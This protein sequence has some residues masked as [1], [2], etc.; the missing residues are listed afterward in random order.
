MQRRGLHG[1]NEILKSELMG[2][3]KGRDEGDL[4]VVDVD[5]LSKILDGRLPDLDQL[6]GD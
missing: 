1:R 6:Q 5:A 2:R 4:S 3:V